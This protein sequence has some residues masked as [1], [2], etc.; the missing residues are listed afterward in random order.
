MSVQ[1]NH[2]VHLETAQTVLGR[3]FVIVILALREMVGFAMVH[4]SFISD[5]INTL[6]EYCGFSYIFLSNANFC[7]VFFYH[8]GVITYTN[9]INHF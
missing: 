6:T 7:R 4:D 8:C 2:A 9:R 5:N 3:F 1:V